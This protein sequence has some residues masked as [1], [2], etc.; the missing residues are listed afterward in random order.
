MAAENRSE[1]EI[2]GDETMALPRQAD[3]HAF[4][5]HCTGGIRAGM[6]R[7]D[8]WVVEPILDGGK[9]CR[10][11][12]FSKAKLEKFTRHAGIPVIAL[13]NIHWT[14]GKYN[15]SWSPIIP[16]QRNHL[17]GPAE[18]WSNV[19]SNMTRQRKGAALRSLKNPTEEE[20]AALLDE[21]TEEERLARSISLS[22]RSMD[23]SIEQIAEFYHE[24]LVNPMSSGHLNGKRSGSMQDQTLFAHV[25]S[26]FL[27]LGAAR[28]YLGALIAARIGQNPKKIDSMAGLIR[29]LAAE[30]FGHDKLLDQLQARGL[31]RPSPQDTKEWEAAGWLK[32]A[33]G[34]C[35]QFV[36]RRP[37]GSRHVERF[38]HAAAIAEGKGLFRYCRPMVVGDTVENDALDVIAKHYK[39]CTALFHEMAQL[40]GNDTSMLRLTDE[41]IISIKITNRQA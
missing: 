1:I 30:H 11:G 24:Q 2:C 34:L 18:L 22:L 7:D 20:I 16:G 23:I 29:V 35:N 6:A 32:E 10:K 39:T 28:D 13:Q 9:A 25:H 26:F 15:S 33:S 4:Y 14:D 38:G 17:L 21:K 40:S 5:V 12:F 41:D 19:A 27:H 31:V 8:A 37:Y 3:V 36:H